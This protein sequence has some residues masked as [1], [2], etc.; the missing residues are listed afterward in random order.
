MADWGTQNELKLNGSVV[1]MEVDASKLG[2]ICDAHHTCRAGVFG[3]DLGG[4]RCGFTG[5]DEHADPSA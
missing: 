5:G 3:E 1:Q 2:R 4:G